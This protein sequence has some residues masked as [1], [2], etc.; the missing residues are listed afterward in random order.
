LN[1]TPQVFFNTHGSLDT[2]LANISPEQRYLLSR[3]KRGFV[4][5]LYQICDITNV[6]PL[7]DDTQDGF[8]VNWSQIQEKIDFQTTLRG[9]KG[10]VTQDDLQFRN[11]L[12]ELYGLLN[13]HLKLL[14]VRITTLD[15]PHLRTA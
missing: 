15:L 14:G 13:H 11:A 1:L 8:D 2:S 10:A 12:A 4:R 3:A 9:V 5:Y 7:A 6:A